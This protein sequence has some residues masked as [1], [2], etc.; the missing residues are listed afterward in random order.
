MSLTKTHH[1]DVYD[2]IDPKTTLKGAAAGKT[3][4]ITGA[5]RGI[6]K[7]IAEQ[8]ALAGAATI[9]I[10]SRTASQLEETAASIKKLNPDTRVVTVVVDAKSVSDNEKLFAIVKKELNGASADVG[11]A[12]AGDASDLATTG[13]SEIDSWWGTIEVHLKG[14][15]IFGRAF[16]KAA[17]EAGKEGVL[18]NT[19][20]VGS[21]WKFPTLGA[22]QIA[23]VAINRFSEFV[24]FEHRKDGIRSYA[25]HPGGI[26]SSLWDNCDPALVNNIASALCDTTALSGA[27]CVFLSTQRADWLSGRYISANWDMEELETDFKEKVLKE[28]YLLTTVLGSTV[29]I[30]N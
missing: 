15:Y 6:G 29:D 8:F 13:D 26:R 14:T 1:H 23:K 11:I 18:I 24:D 16:I 12:N 30:R 7:G 19:S 22:Y 3:I 10:T 25:Y 17:K 21:Y 28:G 9:F 5:G 27:T 20:S 2:F 4:I